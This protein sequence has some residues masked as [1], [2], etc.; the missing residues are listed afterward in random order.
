MSEK[1]A[2][3]RTQEVIP[4]YVLARIS[5]LVWEASLRPLPISHRL[6]PATQMQ[7]VVRIPRKASNPLG[8]YVS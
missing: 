7:T 5:L 4:D 1:R 2:G 3:A 8:L 6:Y